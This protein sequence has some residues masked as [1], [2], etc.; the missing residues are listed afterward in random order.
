MAARRRRQLVTHAPL[1][2]GW[3]LHI[4][5]VLGHGAACNVDAL[6]LQHGSNLLVGEGLGAI[7]LFDHF[8]HFALQQQK[9]RAA[10][11]WPLD[12]LREEIAELEDA[13]RRMR[14]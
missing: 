13:L 6:A 4:L 14:S 7:L 11:Q 1:M 9:W 10:A 8:L 3:Y 5:P 12:R 2:G